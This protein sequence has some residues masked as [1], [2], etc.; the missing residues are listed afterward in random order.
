MIE[1]K[2]WR[3]AAAIVGWLVGFAPTVLLL[4]STTADGTVLVSDEA[5]AEY[6]AKTKRLAELI[7]VDL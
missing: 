5:C 4:A 6:E 1:K 2:E 7:G 3:E